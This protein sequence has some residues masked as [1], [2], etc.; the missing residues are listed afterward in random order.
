MTYKT[1]SVCHRGLFEFACMPFSLANEP[2]EFQ[3]TM[4]AVVE[5]MIGV[6]VMVYL[7]I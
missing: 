6:F 7:M 5:N 4:Q 3:R 1:A 2:V